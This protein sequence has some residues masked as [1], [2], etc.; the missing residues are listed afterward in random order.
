MTETTKTFVVAVNEEIGMFSTKQR[1]TL[2]QS[3]TTEQ[4][5]VDY[6]VSAGYTEFE[7]YCSTM[8]RLG[9]YGTKQ[10]KVRKLED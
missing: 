5:A 3:V 9:R 1:M 8:E 2:P 6:M 4:E 7:L 10:P